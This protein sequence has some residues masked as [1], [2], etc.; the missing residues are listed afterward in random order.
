MRPN[1][2]LSKRCPGGSARTCRPGSLFPSPTTDRD[3]YLRA[4]SRGT[5]HGT[6]R[7][8]CHA[9]R[10]GPRRWPDSSR[11][12]WHVSVMVLLPRRCM[13]AAV[14]VRGFAV[15]AKHEDHQEE[16]QPA[17]AAAFRHC[18]SPPQPSSRICSDSFDPAR[19]FAQNMNQRDSYY[20]GRPGSNG[21]PVIWE[22]WNALTGRTQKDTINGCS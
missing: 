20:K 4:A 7:R 13:A 5:N 15:I 19:T 3:R 1:R 17:M 2:R 16:P 14:T 22:L 10:A 11:L 9:C 21:T 8:R 12:S 6:T 18:D